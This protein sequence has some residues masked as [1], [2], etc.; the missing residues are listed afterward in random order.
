M[1]NRIRSNKRTYVGTDNRGKGTKTKKVFEVW[2]V[3]RRLLG[4]KIY[5][6]HMHMKEYGQRRGNIEE[7]A[8]KG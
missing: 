2:G 1:I 5:L 3:T 6:R 7:N 4:K 8:R